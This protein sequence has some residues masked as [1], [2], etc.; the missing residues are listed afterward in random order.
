MI[1]HMPTKLNRAA[2]TAAALWVG[3]LLG[4]LATL[5]P[6]LAGVMLLGQL[7]FDGGL[8]DLAAPRQWLGLIFPGIH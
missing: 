1:R 4:N 6:P 7:Y 2:V 5:S 8:R 3:R